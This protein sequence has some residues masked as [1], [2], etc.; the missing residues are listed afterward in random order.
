MDRKNA[1]KPYLEKITA[2]CD[3]LTIN[4]NY[5]SP[6]IIFRNINGNINI[7]GTDATK[8]YYKFGEFLPLNTV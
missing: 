8:D 4:N 7:A 1:L 5:M 6:S 3:T 2:Y